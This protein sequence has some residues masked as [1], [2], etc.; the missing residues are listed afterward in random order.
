[1]HFASIIHFENGSRSFCHSF[2]IGHGL[3]QWRILCFRQKKC[4]HSGKDPH[5]TEDT[6]SGG[7][8]TTEH[9]RHKSPDN[10]R[11]SRERSVDVKRSVSNIR[12]KDFCRNIAHDAKAGCDK[13]L[14][15]DVESVED[16]LLGSICGRLHCVSPS[17]E[18]ASY[19]RQSAHQVE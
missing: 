16:D 19:H 18:G 4:C 8:I 7:R 11:N 14:C 13:K 9:K 1:M 12:W 6:L 3:R 17:Q 5:Q 10:R 2:Q 15:C